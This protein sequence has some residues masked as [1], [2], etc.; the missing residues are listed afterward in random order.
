MLLGLLA[1]TA[2]CVAGVAQA[3][4]PSGSWSFAAGAL[5]LGFLT[6]ALGLFQATLLVGNLHWL[7]QLVHAL[8]GIF[9]IGM[10]HM[11]KRSENK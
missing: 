6:V 5:V 10:G 11:I 3:L 1:V 4:A 2:L 8:L 9:V 7:V